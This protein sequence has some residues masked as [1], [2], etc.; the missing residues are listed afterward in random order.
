MHHRAAL[1]SLVH[2][3]DLCPSEVGVAPDS[4]RTV[5]I[6]AKGLINVRRRRCV[7]TRAFSLILLLTAYPMDKHYVEPAQTDRHTLPN[8]YLPFI[9]LTKY[10]LHELHT[11]WTLHTEYEHKDNIGRGISLSFL[12]TK[13]II[14]KKTRQSEGTFCP[15]I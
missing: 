3:G 7:N 2:K 6:K 4:G 13:K 10:E 11:S 12:H 14:I 9:T 15:Q 5:V 1:C 8:I